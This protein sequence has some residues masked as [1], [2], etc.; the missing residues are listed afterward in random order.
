MNISI[1]MHKLFIVINNET[2]AHSK[3]LLFISSYGLWL[4]NELAG[5]E[6]PAW[7]VPELPDGVFSEVSSAFESE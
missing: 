3:L 6:V 5:A 4:L 7:L 1:F 2:V